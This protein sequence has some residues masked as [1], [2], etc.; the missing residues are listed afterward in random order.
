MASQLQS[1][2]MAK[3]LASAP[4]TR[5]GGGKGAMPAMPMD[6]NVAAR[7][8]G[9]PMPGGMS[10]G[11]RPPGAQ[12]QRP[13]FGI[14]TGKRPGM[15]GGA[16]A[17]GMPDGAGANMPAGPG[18]MPAGNAVPDNI[19]K[20]GEMPPLPPGAPKD[21]TVQKVDPHSIKIPKP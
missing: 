1:H 13:R 4:P 9:P 21:V 14:P 11:M 19:P 2:P 3:G 16:V 6:P 5:F 7:G 12:G 10:P 8:G 17:G 18:S 15:P 20:P